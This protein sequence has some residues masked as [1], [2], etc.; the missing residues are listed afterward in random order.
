MDQPFADFVEAIQNAR[1]R[2]GCSR[3]GAF[4][5]GHSNG[6]HKLI[7][8]LL[9]KPLDPDAEHNLYYDCYARAQSFIGTHSTSWE[10]LSLL[11]HYGVPTRLLDWTESLATALFFALSSSDDGAHV[12]VLN[13]Y[14]LNLVVGTSKRPR[15]YLAG[16]DS[17]P[18]YVDCFVRGDTSDR[19]RW[20]YNGPVFLQIPWTTDR[21]RAQGGFFTFHSDDQ[22]LDVH[23]KGV[24]SRV[25]LPPAAIDGAR[26]YLELSGVTE[27]TVFPDFVGLSRYL[28]AKYAV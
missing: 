10:V 23:C 9:R 17:L 19:Q 24:A 7:P 25:D 3:S 2:A 8:S 28:R 26:R 6:S 13:G 21:V 27:H 15:V 4:F 12:W 16:I 20:P 18:D 5:R 11:Q 1:R 14:N 22:P